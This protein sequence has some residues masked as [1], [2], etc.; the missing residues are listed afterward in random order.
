MT[1][2]NIKK[3]IAYWRVFS[4]FKIYMVCETHTEVL[5]RCLDS[6]IKSVKWGYNKLTD[7]YVTVDVEFNNGVSAN[8]W[9][10]NR[11]YAWMSNNVFK[12]GECVDSFCTSMPSLKQRARIYYELSKYPKPKQKSCILE[13]I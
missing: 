13:S 10:A 3:A 8:L 2:E 5:K 6:G 11:W 4:P 7:D 12:K 1:M 9:N